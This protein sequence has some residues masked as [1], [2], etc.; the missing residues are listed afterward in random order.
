MAN[1]VTY[2]HC[3][4]H[5]GVDRVALAASYGAHPDDLAKVAEFGEEHN[6]AVDESSADRRAVRLSRT[7]EQMNK[8]FGVQLNTYQY[9][10]GTY[11]SREVH[12]LVPRALADVVNR[13]SGLTD[14]PLARPH[15]QVRPLDVSEFDA[16]QI[17]QIYNFPTGV[18]GTGT[19][20]RIFE[21]GGAYSQVDLD[22]YF[23][24]LKLVYCAINSY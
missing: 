9:P 20:I 11:R 10:G 19:C 24:S 3:V 6:L 14:R 18:D 16:V 7:V 4:E 5:L 13:V 23:A 21:L 22:T 1:L 15:M 12:V 17:G 8:A 2:R